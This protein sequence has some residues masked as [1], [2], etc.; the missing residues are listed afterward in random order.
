VSFYP[1]INKTVQAASNPGLRTN[2]SF[3]GDAQRQAIE[4]CRPI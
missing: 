2:L 1:P 4:L 3:C